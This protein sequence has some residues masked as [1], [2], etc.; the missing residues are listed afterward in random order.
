MLF[1]R[2]LDATTPVDDLIDSSHV[3]V[4]EALLEI[5]FGRDE[6]GETGEKGIESID[7]RGRS[8][9]LVLARL[10]ERLLVVDVASTVPVS[11]CPALLKDRVSRD[12]LGKRR[13]RIL[14][15]EL[16]VVVAGAATD[17]STAGGLQSE[18]SIADSVR[19]SR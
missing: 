13:G 19:K 9:V 18:E 4:N 12:M 15:E 10:M 5:L 1:G 8:C 11:N 14:L 7:M 16:V 2:L 3:V 17:G 6:T